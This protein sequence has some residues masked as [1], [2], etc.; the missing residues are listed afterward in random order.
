MRRA[1][2]ASRNVFSVC[3]PFYSTA[4]RSF[5]YIL[6]FFVVPE[7]FMIYITVLAF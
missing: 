6:N 4:K 2:R 7:K 1:N 3:I 5:F